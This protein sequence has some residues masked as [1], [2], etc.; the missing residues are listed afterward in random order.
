VFYAKCLAEDVEGAVEI[1]SDILT[2]STFGEQEIER[3]RGVILREMQEVEMNLQEVV[4]DHLHAVAYQVAITGFFCKEYCYYMIIFSIS[5]GG[6]KML[7]SKHY[8]C[9]GTYHLG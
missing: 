9:R 2:N 8:L 4:F 3:E 1:L 7:F 6:F 5:F